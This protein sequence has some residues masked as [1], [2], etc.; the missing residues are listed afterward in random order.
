MS[1]LDA[2]AEARR[3]VEEWWDSLH[4]G[5][6]KA[7]WFK[8]KQSE[9][10]AVVLA[11]L[12]PQIRR[13]EEAERKVGELEKVRDGYLHLFGREN[14]CARHWQAKAGSAESRLAVA[15]EAL[16]KMADLPHHPATDP[17]VMGNMATMALARIAAMGKQEPTSEPRGVVNTPDAVPERPSAEE[18]QVA[19]PA[20][21]PP[22][23]PAP[24]P[25]ERTCA[26]CGGKRRVYG[27]YRETGICAWFDC[28]GCTGRSPVA[29]GGERE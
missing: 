11:A 27:R 9:I 25:A 5:D 7:M 2:R 28:P 13:A 10:E 18:S 6:L 23:S 12:E 22:S 24:P 19:N 1:D 26:E 4:D 16:E 20:G 29:E 17:Y 21:A 3:I 14:E 8:F 15:V